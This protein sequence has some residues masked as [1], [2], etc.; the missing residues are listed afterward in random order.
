MFPDYR[1]SAAQRRDRMLPGCLI[2]GVVLLV[3]LVLAAYAGITYIAAHFID[4]FW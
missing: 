1:T 2:A 3:L 4:K